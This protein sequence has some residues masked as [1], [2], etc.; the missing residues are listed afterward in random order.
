VPLKRSSERKPLSQS[1]KGLSSREILLAVTGSVAAYKS[2][3]LIRRL[4]DEGA[5]VS[6]IMTE[7]SK[8]FITPLSL[9]LASGRRALAGLFNEPL[10]HIDLPSRA[11]VFVIAPATANIIAKLANGIADDLVST[12]ALAYKGPLIIAPAM[13]WRMYENP[14]FRRNLKR[15][16]EDGSTVVEPQCGTLACGEVGVGKMASPEAIISA[17]KGSL[18]E[19]DLL[20]RKLIITAGPTREYIDRVRFISNP[21][22]GKMG[23]ALTVES[24]QR[25]ADVV[26][27]SG[28]V[29]LEPPTGV[30][31][32]EVET[33]KE[34]RDAVFSN[35]SDT[36]AVI[37]SAAPAD[38]SPIKRVEGKLNKDS[39]KNLELRKTP[40]ILSELGSIK[41]RDFLLV[42]F[43]AEAGENI[44]RA[45]RKLLNKHS[46]IIVLNDITLEGSGFGSD[47]NKVVIIDRKRIKRLPLMSKSEVAR[48]LI[49]RIVRELP[50]NVR[51]T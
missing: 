14:A 31:Y 36:D 10:S 20:G 16:K 21:S 44:D 35:L 2:A 30:R 33:T 19:K 22:S 7:A 23:F 43:S 40:D 24:A 6:V 47:S 27:I 46:D 13:N 39:I 12:S 34:M 15:I 11:D 17:I 32:I 42:G 1:P 5:G 38:F 18:R 50:F 28:P 45:K 3:E 8:R 26:L 51:K 9:E 4:R 49:D 25:G 48:V 37:M 29:G 41:G